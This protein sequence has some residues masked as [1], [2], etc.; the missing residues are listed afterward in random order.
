[1][2]IVRIS[3]CRKRYNWSFSTISNQIL[4]FNSPLNYQIIMEGRKKKIINLDVNVNK[5][6][7]G[8]EKGGRIAVEHHRRLRT[9]SWL[10]KQGF[11]TPSGMLK[12]HK[13]RHIIIGHNKCKHTF[14]WVLGKADVRK[15][16]WVSSTNFRFGMLSMKAA[17]SLVAA[18]EVIR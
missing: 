14:T 8:K 18:I 9:F 7:D 5:L 2:K 15:V 12:L 1:L 16:S 17:W 10:W 4:N 11:Q 3:N 13:S 6:W